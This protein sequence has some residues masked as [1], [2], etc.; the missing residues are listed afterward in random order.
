MGS[1]DVARGLD[2]VAVEVSGLAVDR[3]FVIERK[4]T[5]ACRD[6]NK[7]TTT[8]KPQERRKRWS[9]VVCCRTSKNIERDAVANAIP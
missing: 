8:L 2:S 3:T 7:A 9:V 4:S 1:H 6:P 5:N